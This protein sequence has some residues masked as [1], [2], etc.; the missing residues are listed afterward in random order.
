MLNSIVHW[1]T[2]IL[3]VHIATA[4]LYSNIEVIVTD[5]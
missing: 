3:L 5:N 2:V 4:K 1:H